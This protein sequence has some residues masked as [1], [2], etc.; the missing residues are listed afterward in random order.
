MRRFVSALGGATLFLVVGCGGGDDGGSGGPN[1]PSNQSVCGG[2]VTS[3]PKICDLE[4]I[5]EGVV[6]GVQYA[7]F[8]YCVSDA[9]GD[10]DSVCAGVSFNGV[11]DTDCAALAPSGRQINECRQTEAIAIAPVG[12]VGVWTVAFDVA[13]RAGNVS[14]VAST[15]F[16]CCS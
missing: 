15:Q 14:N 8:R 9:E 12:V 3:T 6:G 11:V 13:D 2:A 5:D 10:L 16:T 4:A 7:S 1:P